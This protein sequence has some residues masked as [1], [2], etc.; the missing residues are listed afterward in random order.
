MPAPSWIVVTWRWPASSSTRPTSLHRTDQRDD[1]HHHAHR[2]AALDQHRNQVEAHRREGEAVAC[3]GHDQAP[4]CRHA[5]R[6]GR[7]DCCCG[8]PDAAVA[9]GFADRHGLFG[10]SRHEQPVDAGRRRPGSI[11][12]ITS[13]AGRQPM[14][15]IRNCAKGMPKVLASPPRKVISRMRLLVARAVDA[16]DHG[17][18]RLVERHRLAGAQPEPHDVEHRQRMDLRPYEQQHGG[19]QRSAGHQHPAVAAI[20]PGADRDRAQAGHQQARRQRAVE[21]V[22]RPARAPSPSAR[23]TAERCSRPGP[24]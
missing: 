19:Q 16:G 20:D 3:E 10:R 22:A 1:R 24:R 17:E 9:T 6:R 4:E 15:S 7:A 11:T 13:S 12:A 14:R 21:L 5:D 2:H 23:R 8:V 18:G